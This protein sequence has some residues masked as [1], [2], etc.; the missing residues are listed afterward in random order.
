MLQETTHEL[1]SL[2]GFLTPP[3]SVIPVAE[4]D[5]AVSECYN[6]FVGDGDAEDVERQVFERGFSFAHGF[7]V[8]E[9]IGAPDF[10]WH[11]VEEFGILFE[12]IAELAP[13]EAG[14][15]QC[16]P[17]TALRADSSGLYVRSRD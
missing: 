14:H 11:L 16:N 12:C 5:F 1:L 6:A 7:D 4:G 8:D 13:H 3:A 15:Q 2:Q 10:L 17:S 9:T